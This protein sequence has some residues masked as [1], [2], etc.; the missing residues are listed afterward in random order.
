MAIPL[1]NPI[2][3]PYRRRQLA[4]VKARTDR[5]PEGPHR[6]LPRLETRPAI[7][8]EI[9]AGADSRL[10]DFGKATLGDRYLLPGEAYQDVFARVAGAYAD[11]PHHAARLYRYM[12]RLWFMPATPI[13]TNAGSDR[14]LP[15]SCFLHQSEDS[16]VSILATLN[17]A[18]WMGAMGGGVGTYWGKLRSI[19]ERI[20]QNGK[21]SGPIPF[22]RIQDA[23]TLAVSQGAIR[24]GSAAVFMPI[25]H[26]EIE[27]FIELRK[28]SGDY[29]RRALNL[30]HGVCITDDFMRAVL[31]DREFD[32]KSPRD[33]R[34]LKTVHARELFERL[35]AT[36]LQ[37]GEPYLIFIDAVNRAIPEHHRQTG[38]R[39]VQSNLCSEITLPTG[40]DHHGHQR[41]A[42]CC[43]ASL[44][45]ETYDEWAAE[46]PTIVADILRML[47]NVLQDFIER[48]PESLGH[49]AYSAYRERSVGLGVMGFHS[50]LQKQSIPFESA[51]AKSF[52][53]R[54]FGEIRRAADAAS[55]ALA[56]EKGACPDAG[57][58]GGAE[59]F[60]C[61]LAIAPTA[62]I[63]IIAGGASPGIDPI[64]ANAFVHK[65]LSGSFEVRNKS[66]VECLRRHGRN[67]EETWRSIKTNLGS[68]QHLDF[69]DAA[70]KAI[71]KTA[72]EIDQRWI[73]QHA[74]DRTPFICQAAST[75]LF[76]PEDISAW[77]LI[78]IHYEAWEL[79]L[80]SLYYCRSRSLQRPENTFIKGRGDVAADNTLARPEIGIGEKRDPLYLEDCFACQ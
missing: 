18:S 37:T 62:S 63:S 80:K 70:E 64:L 67:D 25:D 7:K 48:A 60:S 22:I 43:L 24:R 71:F 11:N 41:S 51:L 2:S 27:E 69:L 45:L 61:K 39:V 46:L 23:A 15:I 55:R 32:L 14:G 5:G 44:N 35:V 49:A 10:T 8:V 16:L 17:E 26:P 79:G 68:V 4:L 72:F 54:L 78:M 6:L 76:L 34:T 66:L 77:D 9:D 19:G 21:T 42:V 59:R 38:L 29:N 20:G 3:D 57:E 28:P 74:A 40:I 58:L 12:S 52:N 31:N 53:L 50:Y 65:T 33:G 75:N 36:R 73:V 30:H 47:D 1:R 56:M 13:L